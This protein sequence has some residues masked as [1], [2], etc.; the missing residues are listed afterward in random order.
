MKDPKKE[1]LHRL[2]GRVA[3]CIDC[4]KT[5]P[6]NENLPFFERRPNKEYDIFYC[7]CYGWD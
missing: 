6:S 3:K 5:K 1:E 4:G 2:G 7:G